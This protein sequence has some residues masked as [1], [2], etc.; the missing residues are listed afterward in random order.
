M[1]L[2]R[3]Y[4]KIPAVNIFVICTRFIRLIVPIGLIGAVKPNTNAFKQNNLKTASCSVRGKK[5]MSVKSTD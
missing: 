2:R 5:M 4:F 3:T 1:Q